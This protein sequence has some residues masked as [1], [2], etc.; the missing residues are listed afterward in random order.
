MGQ[1]YFPEG[2][3]FEDFS[4]G[5]V[6]PHAT[7][8][9]VS[10]GDVALY[11]A[12]YG[13]RQILTSSTPMAQALGYHA[14]PL[15]DWLVFHII[16]GK[17]VA[18][19]SRHALANLGYA[20]GRFGA[21]VYVGDTLSARSQ[22]IGLR[23]NKSGETGLVMVETQG[24]N[25]N[26]V[27]VLSYRRWVMVKK[28]D[29]KIAAPQESV[30]PPIEAFVPADSLQLAAHIAPND[31]P[32]VLDFTKWDTQAA[33]S[34]RLYDDFQ[35]GETLHHGDGTTL[36]EAEHMMATRSFQNTAAVHFDAQL[37]AESRFAKRL[38]YGGHIISHAHAMSFNGLENAACVLALNGGTHAAPVFAGDTI[39]GWSE[40]VDKANL[41]GR[42]DIGA[43][44]VVHYVTKNHNGAD[45]RARDEDGKWVPP[46]IL[47]LDVWLAM[48]R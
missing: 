24:H 3:F 43:L 27:L 35:I 40:I 30:W 18:D 44:R 1:S 34:P 9:S 48:P 8:R 11:Q 19:I 42:T 36:E 37:Q 31:A 22:V 25:Q 41:P 5:E 15:N 46:L 14:R 32:A 33:G 38:I 16:F 2:R 6:M 12:L 17:T 39:Y 13:N 23:E 47:Q 21:P 29:P 26:G 45:M 20:S 28:R 10:D 4:L 7:P